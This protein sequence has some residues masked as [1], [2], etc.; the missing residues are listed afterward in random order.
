MLLM[1]CFGAFEASM[2]QWLLAFTELAMGVSKMVGDL[3]GS[4]L[5]A[6][7]M[8]ISRVLYGRMSE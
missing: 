1:V 5:F 3:A 6:V 8:G 7:L 4:C 2:A